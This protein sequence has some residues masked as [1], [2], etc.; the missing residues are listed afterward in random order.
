MKRSLI[1]L[2]LLLTVQLGLSQS[3]VIIA[4]VA[5]PNKQKR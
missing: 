2:T 4:P 3:H 1:Y 5:F